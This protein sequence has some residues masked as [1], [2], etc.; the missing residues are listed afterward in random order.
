MFE[1]K[2]FV[3][4]TQIL[5]ETH[6]TEYSIYTNGK[7]AQGLAFSLSFKVNSIRKTETKRGEQK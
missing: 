7:I 6:W 5:M 4:C 3:N 2:Y 1:C